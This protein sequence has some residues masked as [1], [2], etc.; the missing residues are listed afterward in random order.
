MPENNTEKWKKKKE[1]ETGRTL[2]EG[3]ETLIEKGKGWGEVSS[4]VGRSS[5][6]RLL[7]LLIE[8]S[9]TSS[10]C[11]PNYNSNSS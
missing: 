8:M 6:M 5:D 2:Q 11:E 1:R 10:S 3:A 9:P 7:C 4:L